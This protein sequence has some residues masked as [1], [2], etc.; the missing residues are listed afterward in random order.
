MQIVI[1]NFKNKGVSMIFAG[2]EDID[3]VGAPAAMLVSVA[4]FL[5]IVLRRYDTNQASQ[6]AALREEKACMQKKIDELSDQIMEL[7]RERDKH[8]S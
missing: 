6:I 8:D 3:R 7:L 4:G 1:S 5:V 2:L